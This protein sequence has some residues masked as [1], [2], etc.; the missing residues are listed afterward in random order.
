MQSSASAAAPQ[1]LKATPN[2]LCNTHIGQYSSFFYPFLGAVI[3][4][5]V[6]LASVVTI[7]CCILCAPCTTKGGMKKD[8]GETIPNRSTE[9]EPPRGKPPGRVYDSGSMAPSSGSGTVV[10]EQGVGE[11]APVVES[12]YTSVIPKVRI[13]AFLH[14]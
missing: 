6:L 2:V 8:K 3:L 12:I 14:G 11:S 5:A 13:T 7:C 4:S 10:T 1:A 9:R